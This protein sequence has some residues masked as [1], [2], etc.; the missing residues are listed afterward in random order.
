MTRD[1]FDRPWEDTKV[2]LVD[3]ATL[4]QAQWLIVGCEACAT[5]SDADVP[6]N[7]VLDRVTGSDPE[8]T[9]YLLSQPATCPKCKA[10][11]REKTFVEVDG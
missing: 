10:D 11:I 4:R 3:V 9:D 7:W 2:V 6:F 5:G 8:M 1:F